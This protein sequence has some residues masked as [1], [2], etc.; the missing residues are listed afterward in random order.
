MTV[1]SRILDIEHVVQSFPVSCM[2]FGTFMIAYLRQVTLSCNLKM[3]SNEVFIPFFK[4]STRR[5]NSKTS[6]FPKLVVTYISGFA[7]ASIAEALVFLSEVPEF[8]G[9][10]SCINGITERFVSAPI[11]YREDTVSR[12]GSNSCESVSAKDICRY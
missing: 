4:I 8:P 12:L 5:L 3:R 1:E 9:I 6:S 11:R 10:S 7:L 2:M